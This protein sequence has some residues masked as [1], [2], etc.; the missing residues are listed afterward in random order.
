MQEGKG[1]IK[2]NGVPLSL[3]GTPVLRGKVYEPV[4][5][6]QSFVS[7]TTSLPSPLSRMDIRLRVSGGGHTS[8]LYALRQ[9]IAK[10]VVAYVAK[11]EDAA[12]ALEI[13]KALVAYDR[14]LLVADP[15]RCEPKKF[16]GRSP[17]SS[18]PAPTSKS[19]PKE[20][21][22]GK[23]TDEESAE[24][25]FIGDRYLKSTS[26]TSAGKVEDWEGL[27]DKFKTHAKNRSVA[28][29]RG[30][31]LALV[32]KRA[33]DKEK[34]A[35]GK[36]PEHDEAAPFSPR[37][38]SII[39]H[40]TAAAV[41]YVTGNHADPFQLVPSPW[42]V[43]ED[44]ALLA[45]LATM[46]LGPVRW[47]AVHTMVQK[48]Y[49]QAEQRQFLRTQQE[50]QVRWDSRWSKQ[51]FWANVPRS[52]A[53]PINLITQQLGQGI[54]QFLTTSDAAFA[55]NIVESI[56]GAA[57]TPVKPAVVPPQHSHTP[58]QAGP[59]HFTQQPA[60]T[61]FRRP[62]VSLPSAPNV[63]AHMQGSAASPTPVGPA[64]TPSS[65]LDD[66]STQVQRPVSTGTIPQQLSSPPAS[67]S[68]LTPGRAAPPFPYRPSPTLATSS[69][70]QPRSAPVSSSNEQGLSFM[71][72]E[73]GEGLGYAS[74]GSTVA[75]G[76]AAAG[77]T[78]AYEGGAG[79]VRRPEEEA[80]DEPARKRTRTA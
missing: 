41:A 74:P 49:E 2:I 8:Q 28:A 71:Q 33:K 52:L 46:P 13:R 68:H 17:E 4:L 29:L 38:Q 31:Y 59:S 14:S 43:A 3:Y 10:A 16:G 80:G 45:T 20:Y 5:I 54:L 27:R 26:K 64:R 48:T 72:A 56:G 65:P 44:A 18:P 63:M 57:L 75:L 39:D 32:K 21:R 61:S 19:K 37:S 58:A 6:L 30:K 22:R 1:L 62:S 11:Y 78:Q 51:A 36:S 42:T 24:V 77:A 60:S 25:L 66:A 67:A 50:V 73:D 55:R 40:G 34:A 69:I 9:A 79:D 23:W 7:S 12:S 35:E 15:R 70:S 47:P 76:Q 53:A